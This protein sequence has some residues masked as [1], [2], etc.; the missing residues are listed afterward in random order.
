LGWVR[1]WGEHRPTGDPLLGLL[2]R[3]HVKTDVLYYTSARE[4]P[5]EKHNAPRHS[6]SNVFCFEVQAP[7]DFNVPLK[8]P[9]W[10][11]FLFGFVLLDPSGLNS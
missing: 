11:V 7:S 10:V 3:K 8:M 5:K 9:R 1:G 4:K 6:Q 2:I